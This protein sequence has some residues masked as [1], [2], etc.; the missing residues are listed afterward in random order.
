[1]GYVLIAPVLLTPGTTK[2]EEMQDRMEETRR[3]Q[4]AEE[5]LQHLR[6]RDRE[7][8]AYREHM[9][10]QERALQD[11]RT[12]LKQEQLDRDKEFQRELEAR[13]AFFQDRERALFE[14]QKEVEQQLLIRQRESDQ[15]RMRLEV[16]ITKREAELIDARK[17]VEL[18]KARYTEESRKKI[19]IKSKDYVAAALETLESKERQFQGKSKFWSSLGAWS[20]IGGL[21]LF[22]YVTVMSFISLPPVLSWEYIVFSAFKGLV[23]LALFAALAKYAYVLGNLYMREALKNGD[24]RHAINFG[25]F[26]LESYGAAADWSQIKDA[27]EHWNIDGQNGFLKED[28]SQIDLTSLEKLAAALEKIGKLIPQPVKEHS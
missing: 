16:E 3:S 19:E 4:V 2:G 24:R 11:E 9:T 20:L 22:G 17:R 23:G 26:Y 18:E 8:L 7:L 14:R 21:S 13:E 15:L 1:M 6:N 12:R 10:M 5:E 25:K 28:K 27:F